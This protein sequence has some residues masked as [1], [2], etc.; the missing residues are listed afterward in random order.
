MPHGEDAPRKTQDM[1]ETLYLSAG[2]RILL[3]V[4]V[5]REIRS[6]GKCCRQG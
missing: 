6:S 5:E 4:S 2:L 3:E 1:L